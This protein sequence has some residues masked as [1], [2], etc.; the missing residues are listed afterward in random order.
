M[1]FQQRLKAL[2]FDVTN[3]L[4]KARQ[5][6]GH[7]YADAARA[8]GIEANAAALERVFEPTMQQKKLE[9]PDYG[10]HHGVTSRQ[11]WADLVKRVF[12]N[13]GHVDV[14]P[15]VLSKVC[16][17]L[18]EHF[19]DDA[20]DAWEVLPNVIE[21]LEALRAQGLRL[22]VVSNF[23]ATLDATL[24]AHRLNVY[25]DFA[26]SSEQLGVSKPKPGIFQK[27]IGELNSGTGLARKAI[28]AGQVGHVGDELKNDVVA[29]RQLGM[30]AFMIDTEGLM[31]TAL[32]QRIV[33]DRRHIVRDIK[34]IA[35]L[36]ATSQG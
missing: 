7:Q 17:T 5:S 12:I 20:T 31:S 22:G 19:Q 10:K 14:S 34:G 16:D 21:G 33:D 15:M 25:F 27:A 30:T 11:W 9:M 28:A 18:W 2:T 32:M 23:D 8:H 24:R 4:I 35:N 36:L 1:P 6:I 26:V 13:A 29:P 3:T